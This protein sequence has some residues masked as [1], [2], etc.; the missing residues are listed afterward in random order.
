M[1]NVTLYAAVFCAAAWLADGGQALAE[2][3]IAATYTSGKAAKEDPNSHTGIAAAHQ[4]LPLGTRVVVRNQ[5]TGKSIVARIAN[6]SPDL[7]GKI[8]DLSADAM[9]ALRMEAVAPVCI[10]VVSYGS[11]SRGYQN[12]SMRAPFI[13][14]GKPDTRQ[15]AKALSQT[16]TRHSSNKRIAKSHLSV[17]RSNKGRSAARG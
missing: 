2:C 1:K 13:Q 16:R 11:G 7:L 3:G 15:Y 5:R 10:E 6:R 12:L 4:S 9:N 8:I 14:V 17:R